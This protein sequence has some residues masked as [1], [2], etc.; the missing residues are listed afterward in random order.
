MMRNEKRNVSDPFSDADY[1]DGEDGS[2]RLWGNGGD[3]TLFG[4]A[5]NDH[6]EGDYDS[7]KLAGQYHGNDYL[8]CEAGNDELVGGGGSDTLYGGI[9]DDVLAGDDTPDA[10]LAA[11]YHGN[12]T[13]DG[14]DGA[15]SLYGGLGDDTYILTAGDGGAGSQGQVEFIE[16]TGGIDTMRLDGIAPAQINAFV[17]NGNWLAIDYGAADRVAI[18]N[19]MGGAIER[20]VVSGETLS[21]APFVGRYAASV[22]SGVNADG[23]GV[24]LGGNT[25]DTVDVMNARYENQRRGRGA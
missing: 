17:A 9:G 12:D 18:V 25:A 3:D 24:Q 19:G 5:D 6:L 1:L 13:L 7:Q 2:D 22:Q 15:D 8:D 21:Y 14:G 10:P 11:Q 4:G 20:I 16:D 23:Y